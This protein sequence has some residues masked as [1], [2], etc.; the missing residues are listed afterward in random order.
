MNRRTA[1]MIKVLSE[2]T[3][4]TEKSLK[5]EYYKLSDKDRFKMKKEMEQALANPELMN[6]LIEASGIDPNIAISPSELDDLEEIQKRNEG[7]V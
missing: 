3:G 1:K 4:K 6:Q 5:R 2:K 7:A